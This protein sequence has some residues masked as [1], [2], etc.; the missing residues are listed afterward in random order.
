MVGGVGAGVLDDGEVVGGAG[1]RVRFG[2]EGG[3]GAPVDASQE[4]EPRGMSIKAANCSPEPALVPFEASHSGKF[5]EGHC[6]ELQGQVPAFLHLF[7]VGD[8]Q[9]QNKA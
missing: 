2:G 3:G 1:D 4:L 7:H 6:V 5:H 9:L 8:M